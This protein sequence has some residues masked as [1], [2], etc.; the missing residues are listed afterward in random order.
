[1]RVLFV[2][3]GNICRSP[4]GEAILRAKASPQDIT[5]DSAAMSDWHT[6]EPP[7]GPMRAAARARG[8]DMSDLRAR[9]VR[10]QDFTDF[11]LIIAMD[12]GHYDGLM[13]IAPADRTARI[14]KMGDYA[15]APWAGADVPD[16]YYTRDFAQT[17]DILENAIDGM[18]TDLGHSAL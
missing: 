10:P 11:D 2:C 6:G 8:Y 5:C 18:L 1:M 7:Y 4:T 3:T 14:V 15:R 12:Q 17:L 9:A 13:K 16:P